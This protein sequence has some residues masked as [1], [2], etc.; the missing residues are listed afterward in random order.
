[1]P[2]QLTLKEAE[3]AVQILYRGIENL[4]ALVDCHTDRHTGMIMKGHRRYI[5]G[6]ESQI[7]R[8]RKLR[9]AIF[10]RVASVRKKP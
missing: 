2:I 3:L 6:V 1:M 7:R 10:N 4:E 8:A 9:K 5:R